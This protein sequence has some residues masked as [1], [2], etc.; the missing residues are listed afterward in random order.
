M[1]YFVIQTTDPDRRAAKAEASSDMKM[2]LTGAAQK[3]N[4]ICT[5]GRKP[6]TAEE[7]KRIAKIFS[8]K[9]S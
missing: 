3:S 7:A 8:E 4:P 6:P 9:F 1:Y 5:Q 2:R